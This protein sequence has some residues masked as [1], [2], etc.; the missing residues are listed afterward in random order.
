MVYSLTNCCPFVGEKMSKIL[1]FYFT[2]FLSKAAFAETPE[3]IIYDTLSHKIIIDS[4]RAGSHDPSGTND[5]FFKADMM[6]LLNSAEERNLEDAKKKKKVSNLGNFG[7]TNLLSLGR[8][9]KDEKNPDAKSLKIDGDKV[10]ELVAQTMQELKVGEDDIMVQVLITMV[11]KQKKHYV[12]T[13]EVLVGQAH[14][15]PIP[16][17][18][19]DSPL[20]VDQNLSIA[21]PKGVL[22]KIAIKY[23]NPASPAKPSEGKKS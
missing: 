13:E 22:V 19:F 7:E 3:P 12:L 23:N 18:K 1:F 9:D 21:D 6:A 2:V 10:R 4:L 11:L 20:R 16:P 17:T 15:Y 14:Y 5:Y 8:W